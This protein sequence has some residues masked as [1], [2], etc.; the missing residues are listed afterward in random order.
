[1]IR[2]MALRAAT[3]AAAVVLLTAALPQ[4][5]EAWMCVTHVR[6]MTG[7]TTVRGDAWAW[8]D[9]SAEQFARGPIPAPGSIMVWRRAGNL[10]RGH[11]GVVREIVDSRTVLIDHSWDSNALRRNQRIEDVSADNDWSRVSVWYEPTQTMG[12]EYAL[13]GFVYPPGTEPSS[14]SLAEMSA[15]WEAEAAALEA[16]RAAIAQE[17]E[18]AGLIGSEVHLTAENDRLPAG[19]SVASDGLSEASRAALVIARADAVR[20]GAGRTVTTPYSAVRATPRSDGLTVDPAILAARVR[21]IAA[22]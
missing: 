20:R 15:Q 10:P 19:I 13:Y 7:I 16:A 12:G 4:R 6:N 18:A 22:D 5:A 14:E 1:M 21:E 2:S 3:A 17:L 9:N 11:V 8:W